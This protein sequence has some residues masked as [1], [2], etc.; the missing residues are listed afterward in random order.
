MQTPN[1]KSFDIIDPIASPLVLIPD[2]TEVNWGAEPLPPPRA[3]YKRD[4]EDIGDDEQ[5]VT[6]DWN[7]VLP[8]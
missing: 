4:V 1:G 2:G 7:F 3:S 5:G 8:G 6:S